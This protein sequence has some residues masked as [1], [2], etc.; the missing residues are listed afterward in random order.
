MR[1][2]DLACVLGLRL[3]TVSEW[4]RRGLIPSARVGRSYIVRR[5]ALYAFLAQQE[6]ARAALRSRPSRLLADVPRR[7]RR[8]LRPAQAPDPAPATERAAEAPGSPVP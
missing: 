5:E 1:A 4:L 8:V 6:Q 2:K 7:R 3:H